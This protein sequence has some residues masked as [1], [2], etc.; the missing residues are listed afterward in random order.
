M[1]FSV[2]ELKE[3]LAKLKGLGQHGGDVFFAG[4]A[5]TMVAKPFIPAIY[6]SF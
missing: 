5:R 2:N 6:Q 3:C 1:Y 4:I